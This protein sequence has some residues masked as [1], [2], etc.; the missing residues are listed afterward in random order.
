MDIV[1]RSFLR[2][3]SS[4]NNAGGAAIELAIVTPVLAIV[5]VGVAELGFAIRERMQVQESASA[6]ALY[7]AQHG[8]NSAA[9][10]SAVT[11]NDSEGGVT[12]SPAPTEF[13]GCPSATA[14]TTATCGAN[15]ADGV[16][17][18]TYVKVNATMTRISIFPGSLALPATFTATVTTRIQ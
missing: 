16:V 6:G 10:S 12:A 13:C 2:R 7:A 11:S 14:I 17:S 1:G 15:C 5:L 3:V 8:W 9:I 18:R 4:L